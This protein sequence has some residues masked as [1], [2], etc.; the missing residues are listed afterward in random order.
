[1][2]IRVSLRAHKR[3]DLYVGQLE[4][5]QKEGV[6]ICGSGNVETGDP[7]INVKIFCEEFYNFF[8][9]ISQ[10]RRTVGFSD[11]NT[12]TPLLRGDMNCLYNGYSVEN[13]HGRVVDPMES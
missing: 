11:A 12:V 13:L 6:V 8:F 9:T 3:Q 5:F 7:S 10:H 2:N 1:M 4:N